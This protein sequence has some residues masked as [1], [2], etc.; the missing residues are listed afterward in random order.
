MTYSVQIVLNGQ[1]YSA[2]DPGSVDFVATGIPALS[3]SFRPDEILFHLGVT[4]D[5]TIAPYNLVAYT[6]TVLKDGVAV[7]APY[8]VPNQYW[9]TRWPHYINAD[10]VINAPADIV[11]QGHSFPYGKFNGVSAVSSGIKWKGPG[12]LAGIDPNMGDTGERGDLDFWAEWQAIFMQTGDPTDM[13]EAA[14]GQYAV[15][16]WMM[17][18]TTGAPW[19]ML[20]NPFETTY[21]LDAAQNNPAEYIPLP[22]EIVQWNAAHIPQAGAM[23][24]FAGGKLRHLEQLQ[25]SATYCLQWSNFFA[26]EVGYATIDV[27]QVRSVA[28]TGREILLAYFATLLAEKMYGTLPK[29]LL[30]SS[31]WKQVWEN[32]V[33][34]MSS[35]AFDKSIDTFRAWPFVGFAS[36]WQNDMI[37]AFLG[38]AVLFDPTIIPLY[39]RSLQ[40]LL[41]RMDGKHGWP[42]RVP[43]NYRTSLGPK[44]TD[45]NSGNF[46]NFPPDKIDPADE[47]PDIA[48]VWQNVVKAANANAAAD[49][50]HAAA[51]SAADADHS[52][53]SSWLGEDTTGAMYVHQA[54][55]IAVILK[56]TGRV[57]FSDMP[58]LENAYAMQDAMAQVQAKAF[59][60]SNYFPARVSITVDALPP[61]NP[62]PTT[63]PPIGAITMGKPVSV[64]VGQ[65]VQVPFTYDSGQTPPVPCADPV[66]I[67]AKGSADGL[68]TAIVTDNKDGTGTI[69][70]VG[71]KPSSAGATLILSA[72][73]STGATAVTDSSPLTVTAQPPLVGAVHLNP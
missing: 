45:D 44:W 22:A 10:F 23:Q 5:K 15:P 19:D 40:G 41:D 57:D 26:K 17:D 25:Y 66:A 14:K 47:Y 8:T 67:T 61:S 68:V 73:G 1:N 34:F 53:I 24:F 63:Q 59:T 62:P 70:V 42:P 49:P 4:R 55:A 36:L 7:V 46:T 30:P 31:Y 60:G 20:A 32:Q 38:F 12:D 28:Y 35:I 71:V 27:G 65:H 52:N 21:S 48:T 39:K 11:N 3:V 37:L 43:Y 58:E 9:G 13:W 6:A 72:L 50:D 51:M 54:L 69:D 16:V 64:Q 56:R 29:Y 18:E 33:K 2:S